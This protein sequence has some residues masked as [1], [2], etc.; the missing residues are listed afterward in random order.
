M[1]AALEAGKTIL[2]PD[3]YAREMYALLRKDPALAMQ[4]VTETFGPVDKV[5]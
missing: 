5:A 1:I 2:F 4:K 3:P